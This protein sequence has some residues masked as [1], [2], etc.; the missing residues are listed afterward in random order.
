AGSVR[1]NLRLGNDSGD[2]GLWEVLRRVGLEAMVADL[3][4]G[5]DTGLG[6]DGY[7]LSAGQRARLTLA[8]AALSSAPLILLDE[9]TA[10]LDDASAA[11]AHHLI[12][13]LAEQRTVVAVTHR[14]ELLTLAD[15]HIRLLVSSSPSLTEV[16]S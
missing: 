11:L 1:E 8:R 15:Q 6:D 4:R 9:P 12:Q 13:G 5:L 16:P 2:E 3:A 14:P 7:G 10:H